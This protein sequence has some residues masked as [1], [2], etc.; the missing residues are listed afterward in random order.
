MIILGCCFLFRIVII[1]H[2]IYNALYIYK[3]ISKCFSGIKKTT[4]EI[5]AGTLKCN[6]NTQIKVVSLLNAKGNKNRSEHLKGDH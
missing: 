5:K 2:F 1:I 6:L 4:N 3:K